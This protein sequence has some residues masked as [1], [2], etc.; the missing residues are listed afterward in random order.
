MR[1][2]TNN[3]NAL[4]FYSL[5]NVNQQIQF[6]IIMIA[7]TLIKIDRIGYNKNIFTKY[8]ITNELVFVWFY[9][10][11]YTPDIPEKQND[12]SL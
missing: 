11:I 8:L 1:C 7:N 4:F 5:F 2:G 3:F 10:Y 12:V 9:K 6:L